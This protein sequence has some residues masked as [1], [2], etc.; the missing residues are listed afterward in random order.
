MKQ[1]IYA[2]LRGITSK[3]YRNFHCLNYLCLYKTK[4]KLDSHEK[5]YGNN[6]FFDVL[7]PFEDTKILEVNEYRI[8]DKTPFIIFAGSKS[9]INS[10]QSGQ[11]RGC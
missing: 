6:K 11:F 8:F 10:I 7:M 2:L 3:Q 1:K 4:S 5:V 9:L